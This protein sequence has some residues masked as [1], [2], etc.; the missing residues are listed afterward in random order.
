MIRHQPTRSPAIALALSMCLLVAC[1]QTAESPPSDAVIPVATPPIDEYCGD[2]TI[3]TS[4]AMLTAN[5]VSGD[6]RVTVECSPEELRSHQLFSMRVLVEPTEAAATAQLEVRADAAM[7]HHAHGMDVVPRTTRDQT[8]DGAFLVEGMMFHM[9]GAWE[10][11]IDI[12]DGPYTE[13][14]TFHVQAR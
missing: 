6:Y 8:G 13:R 7:P 5:S 4:G 2:P 12:V 3:P 10:L 1:D 11:Y 9:P 14:V